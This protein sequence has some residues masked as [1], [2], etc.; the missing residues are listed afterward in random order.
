[1]PGQSIALVEDDRDL[2]TSLEM[3]LEKSGYEVMI[4]S[5]GREGLEGILRDPPDLVL[6]DLN[7]PDLDGFSVCREL[8]ETD[9][10]RDIPLIMLTA[11]IEERDWVL[12]RVWGSI[13]K[14]LFQNLW[15]AYS[16]FPPELYIWTTSIWC[17]RPR[18]AGVVYHRC[19]YEEAYYDFWGRQ[20][21]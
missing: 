8:R 17:G 12:E 5:S 6:L 4:Y 7:L 20:T 19:R 11:R 16:C 9:S 3:A 1:M 2:A 13:C 14:R 10:V 15:I 18:V 21:S